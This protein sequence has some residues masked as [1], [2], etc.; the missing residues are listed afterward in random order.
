MK[1]TR[2]TALQSLH[3]RATAIL[4]MT[5]EINSRKQCRI[6]AIQAMKK[7]TMPD[8]FKSDYLK[9]ARTYA[10]VAAR[11]RKAYSDTLERI[12]RTAIK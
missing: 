6:D 4:Q 1:A 8:Y 3:Q 7:G 11:L 5:Q 9:D 12:N 2:T 10:K